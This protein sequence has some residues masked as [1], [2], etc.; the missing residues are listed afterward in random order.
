[1]VL[2]VD[3]AGSDYASQIYDFIVE[4]RESYEEAPPPSSQSTC[5]RTCPGRSRF[6]L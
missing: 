1:M 5:C 6:R 4:I 2:V 3:P